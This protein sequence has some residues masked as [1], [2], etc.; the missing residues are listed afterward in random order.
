MTTVNGKV[1]PPAIV[2]ID[3]H[4]PSKAFKALRT[5]SKLTQAQA[6]AKLDGVT[7]GQ[8]Y[9]SQYERARF[10]ENWHLAT[11]LKLFKAVGYDVVIGVRKRRA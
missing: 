2:W 1:R 10:G 4:A 5:R 8:H 3:P 7:S 6:G 11:L 9:V